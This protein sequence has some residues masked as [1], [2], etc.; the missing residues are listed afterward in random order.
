[1]R[2]SLGILIARWSRTGGIR[3]LIQLANGLAADGYSV[4]FVV[5]DS[6]SDCPFWLD[7]RVMVK[8]ISVDHAPRRT[9]RVASR[10]CAGWRIPRCD[11][12]IFSDCP[13]AYLARVAQWFGRVRHPLFFVQSYDP[14]LF[15]EPYL[16]RGRSLRRAIA[17]AAYD[18]QQTYV[19]CSTFVRDLLQ[20]GHGRTADVI[21]PGVDTE[22]FRPV[23]SRPGG[24]PFVMTT[25]GRS[26][27]AKGLGMF[28]EAAQIVR[29]SIPACRVRVITS[30]RLL[31]V[32][33]SWWEV[34]SPADDR[35]L[36]EAY[37]CSDVFIAT[38]IFESFM[39]SV[40]EAMACGVPTVSIDNRGLHEYAVH[41]DNC[42]IVP[43]A[44]PQRLADAVLRIAMN[45]DLRQRLVACGP[46]TA[47]LFPWRHMVEAFEAVLS[48]P[49]FM[50]RPSK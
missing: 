43:R 34:V 27:S 21:N 9:R 46:D 13:S 23:G 50:I 35:A 42:L 7:P 18:F 45:P 37:R 20:A 41:E 22:V 30:D 29:H 24:G 11:V 39:L 16:A 3:A 38:S 48:R 25:I 33:P 47:S 5:I 49:E 44:T 36:A 26:L 10:L 14:I 19:G 2:P 15:G 17:A 40:L 4:T 6:G 8:S 28:A 31:K 12:L 32:D 1:M